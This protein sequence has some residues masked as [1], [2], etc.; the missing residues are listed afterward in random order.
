MYT[1]EFQQ[2]PLHEQQETQPADQGT[3]PDSVATPTTQE[4]QGVD[5]PV[6]AVQNATDEWAVPEKFEDTGNALSWYAT[7]YQR[8]VDQLKAQPPVEER[9][10]PL[11]QQRLQ[12]VEQELPG[13]AAFYQALHANPEIALLRFLPEVQER[14]GIAP[15]L[16]DAQIGQAVT[17]QMTDEFGENYKQ[18]FNPAEMLDP[19]SV[20]AQMQRR[21]FELQQHYTSLNEQSK[22]R[23]QQME[24]RVL[25]PEVAQQD[26]TQALETGFADFAKA[27]I[28][29]EQYEQF[30]NDPAT[31][32]KWQ[33]LT[34]YD[35]YRLSNLDRLLSEAKDAGL[36]E[37]K[38]SLYNQLQKEGNAQ[39]HTIPAAVQ[40]LLDQQKKEER[41]PSSTDSWANLMS[42]SPFTNY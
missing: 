15:V 12:E 16:T 23:L 2:V 41:Q 1:E 40:Q 13:M 20:S 38:K 34:P 28:P 25:N 35:L 27:G 18:L 6:E 3:Q 8:A 9:L 33:Q 14:L 5:T 22:Q 30:I 36:Q 42:S 10:Q 39:E 17:D 11:L 21:I 24:Q 26:R 19:Q 7:Q 29:R 4:G 31:N 32:Q 37:G